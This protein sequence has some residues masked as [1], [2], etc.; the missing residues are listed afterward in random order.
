[1]H[2]SEGKKDER[3]RLTP[4]RPREDPTPE[5]AAKLFKP[6]PF[7]AHARSLIGRS[8]AVE[9]PVEREPLLRFGGG[10]FAAPIRS[11]ASRTS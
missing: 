9:R 7:P 2:S 10:G 11:R 4:A 6:E 5:A 8:G 1:M 3:R